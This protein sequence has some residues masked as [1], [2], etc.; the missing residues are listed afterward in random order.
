MLAA[1]GEVNA[2][3]VEGVQ[4]L[5]EAHCVR[6]RPAVLQRL[7]RKTRLVHGKPPGKAAWRRGTG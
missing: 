7:M 6:H 5:R 2:E 3:V 4:G 1:L